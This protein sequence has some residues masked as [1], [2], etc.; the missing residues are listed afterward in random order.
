MRET[1]RM[2]HTP[3]KIENA[4]LTLREL[5]LNN[6][7]RAIISGYFAAATGWWNARSARNWASAAAWCAR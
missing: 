7:R 1:D 4:P 3:L 6:V 5:A 2:T